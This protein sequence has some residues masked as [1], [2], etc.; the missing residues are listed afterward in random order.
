MI[1]KVTGVKFIKEKDGQYGKMYVFKVDYDDK[2]AF[3][4]SK[5]RDQDTFVAGK[6]YEVDEES[7]SGDKGDFLVI[8]PKRSFSGQSNFG[9]ALKK[10]QSRYSGYSCSY[11]KDLAVA[12]L[13]AVDEITKWSRKFFDHMVELDK[14]L[15]Q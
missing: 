4:T 12:K 8:R 15:E 5:K 13:I 14:T 10:E 9:R 11:A 3:Y 7:K 6:E 1:I 2:T